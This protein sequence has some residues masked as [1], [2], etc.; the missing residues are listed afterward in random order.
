MTFSAA[1]LSRIVECCAYDAT[2]EPREKEIDRVPATLRRLVDD[3]IARGLTTGLEEIAEG[4]VMMWGPAA[5]GRVL[6]IAGLMELAIDTGYLDLSDGIDANVVAEIERAMAA[7]DKKVVA[8]VP[9][10]AATDPRIELFRRLRNRFEAPSPVSVDRDEELIGVFDSYVDLTSHVWSDAALQ[11]FLLETHS[12]MK[13]EVQDEDQSFLLSPRHFA[14]A[15][16]TGRVGE[17][18]WSAIPGG[19]A[20]L[21][22]LDWLCKL[23]TAVDDKPLS[24]DFVRHAR[25][26]HSVERVAQ[27]LDV[28]TSAMT[29]WAIDERDY[30]GEA[31]W[32][33]YSARV[34]AR[35]ESD[36]ARMEIAPLVPR[37]YMGVLVPSVAGSERSPADVQQLVNELM[38]QGQ[39][40]AARRVAADAAAT[41]HAW[42]IRRSEK[43]LPSAI[44]LLEICTILA[45]LGDVDTAAAYVAPVRMRASR[46]ESAP[47]FHFEVADAILKQARLAAPI[48]TEIVSPSVMPRKTTSQTSTHGLKTRTTGA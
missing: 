14:S 4:D 17:K 25:W 36:Q 13:T 1:A 32:I 35:L 15:L 40:G 11:H 30:E 33:D 28:W 31:A 12:S 47:Q 44:Q 8:L 29:E 37:Y 48:E 3:S 7:F 10:G 22:R 9:P 45:S 38:E 41:H 34:F 46:L 24:V 39:I 43:W 2:L 19:L 16:A 26:S 18:S 5:A 42:F 20:A 6:T 23:I 21:H 27:R